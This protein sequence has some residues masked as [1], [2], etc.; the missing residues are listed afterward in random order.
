LWD[1]IR[2]RPYDKR[3]PII[4]MMDEFQNYADLNTTRSDPF[5]EARSYGLGLVIA[6]QHTGQLPNAVLSSVSNNTA[7]KIAFGLEPEDARK[8]KDS[9]LP[10]TPE[11]LGVIPRFG[12]V[13]RLMTSTGKAPVT[14]AQTAPPPSPT[15]AGRAALEASRRLYGRPVAEVEREFVERHKSTLKTAD[16]RRSEAEMTAEPMQEGVDYSV[17]RGVDPV[18]RTAPPFTLARRRRHG[19]TGNR[20]N[21]PYSSSL[22]PQQALVRSAVLK[23]GQLT[24]SQIRRLL[25]QGTPDGC[26]VRSSRHLKRLTEL[27]LVRRVWGVYD[28]EAQYIY[29]PA[30]TT[31]RGPV[32]HTLDISELYV[33]LSETMSPS[34]SHESKLNGDLVDIGQGDVN[35]IIFDREPWCHIKIGH[36][37][38]KP[39][40][41]LKF[42]EQEQY[43]IEVDRASADRTKLAKK[44]RQY[45]NLYEA[46][47]VDVDG[48]TFPQVYYSVP[49]EDRRRVIH[50]VIKTQRYPSLFKVALFNEIVE[51]LT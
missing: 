47:D 41:F 30:G 31:S 6:N 28:D 14:T 29:M 13:T 39:D 49:D 44:L 9:F 27:G 22:S 12:V 21:T 15:R 11:E 35:Q 50:S 4:L 34:M 1:E 45:V 36:V 48:E 10:L 32:F 23:H 16:G 17:D 5:A 20:S 8:L 38:V 37:E 40:A 24:S 26:R 19:A 51:R 7:S 25:Y 33:A 3:Q 2:R 42:N 43:F 46:W 18:Q